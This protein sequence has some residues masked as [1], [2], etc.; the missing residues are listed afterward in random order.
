M[1]KGGLQKKKK[2]TKTTKK[3]KPMVKPKPQIKKR[4]ANNL[5]LADIVNQSD[6]SDEDWNPKGSK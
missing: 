5:T 3:Q 2:T 6:E 4:K 1:E